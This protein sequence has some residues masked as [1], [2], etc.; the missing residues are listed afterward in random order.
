M[1]PITCHFVTASF[2]KILADIKLTI[3]CRL[4][5]VLIIVAPK[6]LRQYMYKILPIQEHIKDRNIIFNITVEEGIVTFEKNNEGLKNKHPQ[7][8]W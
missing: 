6:F 7:K 8:A 2:N 5:Y 1:H 4:M 3:G